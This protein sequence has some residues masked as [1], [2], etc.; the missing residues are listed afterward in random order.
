MSF[1]F[2]PRACG[3]LGRGARRLALLGLFLFPL[4]AAANAA[5]LVDDANRMIAL[6]QSTERVMAAGAPAEIMLY[7]LVPE[8]LVGWNHAPSEAL[9][10]L[11][12]DNLE[13]KVIIKRLPER[14]GP[15]AD[16]EMLAL[17]PDI[18][19]DYGDIAEGYKGL[20]DA[21]TARTGIPY[22]IFRGRLRQVPETYRKLGRLLHVE[23]RAE[24]L[25]DLVSGIL[26][27]YG[28]SLNR[29]GH[30][31]RL[32]VTGEADGRVPVFVDDSDWELYEI[33]GALDVAG[34]FDEAHYKEPEIAD[35]AK[36]QPDAIVTTN[37]RFL[38]TVA[39]DP[40]WQQVKAV[41]EKR[42]YLSPRLPYSWAG[43]PPSVNRILGI[44]WA[45]YVLSG[46][47]FDAEFYADMGAL[48]NGMYHLDLKEADIK[49]LME[50][51]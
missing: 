23:D 32:Y 15:E 34:N 40:A 37:P 35:I 31:P 44:P 33:L 28:D 18:V 48:L 14:D 25:A 45:S 22:P 26:L 19:I 16:G 27:K 11:I 41:K 12:P 8:R 46:K 6:P 43:R 3:A 38:D 20:G 39:R 42:V 36:W 2:A 10:R 5:T 47:P 21:V 51:R 17:K 30:P 1:P 24:K 49:A 13:P 4:A 7:T 29:T 50:G 9:K